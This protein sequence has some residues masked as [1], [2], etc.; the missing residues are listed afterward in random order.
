MIILKV[1]I[2]LPPIILPNATI[3]APVIDSPAHCFFHYEDAYEYIY[4]KQDDTLATKTF[5][6]DETDEVKTGPDAM[7][8]HSF[9]YR[10]RYTGTCY[11][12]QLLV[13][14]ATSNSII[15]DWTDVHPSDGYELVNVSITLNGGR[16]YFTVRKD[17]EERFAS[18]TYTSTTVNLTSC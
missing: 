5:Y 9:S 12:L 8:G 16:P 7:E 1:L 15:V 18:F 10:V 17:A 2:H 4:I 6:I 11:L 3:M 13:T 14:G